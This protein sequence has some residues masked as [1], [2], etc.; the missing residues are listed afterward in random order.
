M[1]DLKIRCTPEPTLRRLPLYLG[2]LK[3]ISDRGRNISCTQIANEF[4]FDPTQVR[5]DIAQTGI[6]GTARIGYDTKDLILQIET[7]L[8]W[9]KKH[10]AFLAG[11]GNL[12]TALLK[13]NLFKDEYGLDIVAV[14]ENDKAKQGTHIAGRKVLP[15]DKITDLARRMHVPIGVIA[16]PPEAAQSVADRMIEGGIIGIWNFCPVALKVPEGIIVENARLS[17]SLAV[18]TGK[19]HNLLNA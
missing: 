11:A 18:L 8:G 15:V 4:G 2:F 10:E 14:F 13:Y 9:N 19:L 17:T 1:N 3:G 7:F 5:K 16:I 6:V 12:G